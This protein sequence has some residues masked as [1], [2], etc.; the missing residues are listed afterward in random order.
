MTTCLIDTIRLFQLLTCILV[1]SFCVLVVLKVYTVV[2]RQEIYAT[3]G[4]EPAFKRDNRTPQHL[5][6]VKNRNDMNTTIPVEQKAKNNKHKFANDT[7]GGIYFLK[8]FKTGST[9]MYNML[10]RFAMRNGLRW[11]TYQTRPYEVTDI[12]PNKTNIVSRII[13][14]FDS[15]SREKYNIIADHSV[16]DRDSIEKVLSKPIS[17]ITVLRHPVAHLRSFIKALSSTVFA[18]DGLERSSLDPVILLRDSIRKKDKNVTRVDLYSNIASRQLG[19]TTLTNSTSFEN[20]SSYLKELDDTFVVGLTEYFTTSMIIFRRKL[21]LSWRDIIFIRLRKT[22]FKSPWMKN[23]DGLLDFV[24]TLSPLDCFVYRHFNTSFW[25][26]VRESGKDLQDE[27]YSFKK[28][29]SKVSEYCSSVYRKVRLAESKEDWLSLWD[30]ASHAV[31]ATKWSP[32]FSITPKDCAIMRLN[33][34]PLG[35]YFYFRQNWKA[36]GEYRKST[37]R[38]PTSRIIGFRKGMNCSKL[39]IVSERPSDLINNLLQDKAAYLW[40]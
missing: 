8:I 34:R 13:P 21:C 36:C 28:V 12:T 26:S 10:G 2:Y 35:S 25:D 15:A 29:L 22:T 9:T 1:T 38:C 39:C 16:Y 17:Y 11:A 7:C 3:A 23:D 5:K 20:I 37:R 32:P 33:E 4:Q 40:S 14:N 6:A 18:L 31:I 30:S 27:T 24:C 19:F